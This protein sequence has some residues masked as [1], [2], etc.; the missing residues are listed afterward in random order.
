MISM[1]RSWYYNGEGYF[2]PTEGQAID[3]I[4]HDECKQKTQSIIRSVSCNSRNSTGGSE[5]PN[6]HIMHTLNAIRDFM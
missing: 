4:M 3:N 5:R 6:V 2:C 1:F